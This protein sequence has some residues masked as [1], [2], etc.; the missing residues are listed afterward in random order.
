MATE[1]NPFDR[2][3]K[4]ITNVVPMNPVA[5]GEEQEA[6]FECPSGLM[7]LPLQFCDMNNRHRRPWPSHQTF[8]IMYRLKSDNLESMEKEAEERIRVNR[9]IKEMNK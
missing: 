3:E 6:T 8:F 7:I 5:M 2:I 4:E 9:A 1:R